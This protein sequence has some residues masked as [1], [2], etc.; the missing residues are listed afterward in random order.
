M[1][2]SGEI[3]QAQEKV[4]WVEEYLQGDEWM[5]QGEEEQVLLTRFI[6]LYFNLIPFLRLEHKLSGLHR[7]KCH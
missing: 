5:V 1:K 4:T 7:E 6:T 3:L 2:H